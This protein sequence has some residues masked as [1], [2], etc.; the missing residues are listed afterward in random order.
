M[1]WVGL[2][3]VLLFLLILSLRT[4]HEKAEEK[5]KELEDR[6]QNLESEKDRDSEYGDWEFDD[7]ADDP[8]ERRPSL[9]V[10]PETA[11]LLASIDVAVQAMRETRDKRSLGDVECLLRIR[12]I[13][14]AL[15]ADEIAALLES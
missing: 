6:I 1:T 9:P 5:V 15:D 12:R 11:A 14:E 13:I 10:S 4:R 3:I 2:G 7:A 8:E